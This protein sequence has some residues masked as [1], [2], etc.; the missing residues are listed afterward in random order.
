MLIINADDFGMSGSCSRAIALAFERG[1][2]NS[3]TIMGNGIYFDKAVEL[4]KK[5]RLYAKIGIHFNLTEGKPLTENIKNFPDFVTDGKFNKQYDWTRKL[6]PAEKNAIYKELSAQVRRLEKAGIK[7]MRADSHHYIHNAPFVAP[8]AEKVCKQ[9]GINRLRIMRNWGDMPESQ[10]LKADSY[11]DNLRSKGF[12]VT[13]YFGRLSEAKGRALPDNIELLVHP[14]FDRDGNLIDRRG[15]A[16][17]YPVG[18]K[19]Q[20]IINRE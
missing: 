3:T 11:R 10:R 2:V 14:D 17:G 20:R 16:D 9:H 12:A 18:E 8:I 4:A 5:Q 1:L 6:T 7:I 15:F 13:D 19:L